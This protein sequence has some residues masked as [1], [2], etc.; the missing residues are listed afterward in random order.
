LCSQFSEN[1]W[2][3]I[4]NPSIRV[5]SFSPTGSLTYSGNTKMTSTSSKLTNVVMPRKRYFFFNAVY[6]RQEENYI[7]WSF[8]AHKN[9]FDGTPARDALKVIAIDKIRKW[10]PA[11]YNL[12]W[13]QIGFHM[14]LIKEIF[15]NFLNQPV[16]L[17]CCSPAEHASVLPNSEELNN[18][19]KHSF[20]YF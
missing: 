2:L 5:L 14:F 10:H 20:A 17:R 3:C 9:E 13:N 6:R 12:Y 19:K 1:R 18:K 16:T 7:L 11:F 4:S 15:Q 8:I